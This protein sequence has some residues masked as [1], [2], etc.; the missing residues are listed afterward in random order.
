MSGT[1]SQKPFQT[2]TTPPPS[3]ETAEMEKARVR[4]TGLFLFR[5]KQKERVRKS[6]DSQN[7]S[8]ADCAKSPGICASVTVANMDVGAELTRMYSQRVTEVHMHKAC[9]RQ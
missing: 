1:I 4:S 8:P 5:N 9:G 2:Q 6:E 7:T 3:A